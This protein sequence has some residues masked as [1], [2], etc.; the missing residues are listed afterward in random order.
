MVRCPKC[1]AEIDLDE[2]EVEEGEILTCVE[3]DAELE[4][5]QIH[6]VRLNVISEDDE[7]DDSAGSLDEDGDESDED[8]E[9]ILEEE[10]DESELDE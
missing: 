2:D 8:D 4:V 10:E 7:D 6:P 3:C 5:A 1:D 9:G